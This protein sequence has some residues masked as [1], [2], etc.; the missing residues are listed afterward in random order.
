MKPDFIPFIPKEGLIKLRQIE[1]FDHGKVQSDWNEL[2]SNDPSHILNKPDLTNPGDQI[3]SDWNEN[4]I[5]KP[6]FILN[7]PD[8]PN[9]SEQIQSDWDQGDSDAVDFI[10][11]KPDIFGAEPGADGRSS[12]VYIA[13]AADVSGTGFTNTFNSSLDYIAI[14]SIETELV[15]PVVTDF[16][17]LWKNYKGADG[18]PG[19]NGTNGVGTNG[20]NGINGTNGADDLSLD[21]Y[22]DFLSVTA[23]VYNCPYAMVINSQLS[24]G[25]AATLATVVTTHMA[26]FG[27]ITITPTQIGLI[28]LKGELL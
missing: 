3:Q 18:V 12:F 28:I 19:T 15:S 13:Y 4:D 21:V 20:T 9:C 10:K 1:P 26:Q 16:V 7:K 14:L 2:D 17:G 22:I 27:K 6:G 24:E 11:N 23:F 5:L 25:S 8:I